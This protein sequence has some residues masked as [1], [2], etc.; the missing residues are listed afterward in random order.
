MDSKQWKL[1]C[2]GYYSKWQQSPGYL[3]PPPSFL[4]PPP[5][6]GVPPGLYKAICHSDLYSTDR[7]RFVLHHRVTRQDYPTF[8]FGLCFKC[9]SAL[10]GWLPHSVLSRVGNPKYCLELVTLNAHIFS[11]TVTTALTSSFAPS[12]VSTCLKYFTEGVVKD[13]ISQG[14]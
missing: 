9:R 3:L 6:D 12:M 10:P 8:P 11:I 1:S 2:Y 13:Q 5:S 14:S 7:Q 4:L